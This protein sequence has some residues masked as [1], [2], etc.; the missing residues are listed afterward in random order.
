V[1][2]V[3]TFVRSREDSLTASSEDLNTW[4]PSELR[5]LLTYGPKYLSDKE[6]A[7]RVHY[8]LREYYSYLASHLSWGRDGEFWRYHKSKLAELG[9]PLSIPRLFA[10]RGL[11]ILDLILNPKLTV[12]RATRYMRRRSG[13]PK[14]MESEYGNEPMLHHPASR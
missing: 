9:Y 8:R 13:K 11:Y 14:A 5:V 12:K 7:D 1:H 4:L 10:H 2:Q 3:L 6:L